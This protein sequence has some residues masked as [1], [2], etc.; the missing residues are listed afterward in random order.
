MGVQG[1]FASNFALSHASLRPAPPRRAATQG[2]GVVGPPMW[3][4]RELAQRL[5]Q[6]LGLNLFNFDVIVPLRP[7]ATQ[8]AHGSNGSL[9]QNGAQ[10]GSSAGGGG[11]AAALNGA[12]RPA[13][14]EAAGWGQGQAQQQGGPSGAP[15]Q[16]Q[17]YY[18]I[19]INYFPGYEKLPG[20]EDLMVQ[21]FRSIWPA[22]PGGG[23]Q[24]QQQQQEQQGGGAPA[25][26]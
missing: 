3:L 10:N 17:L 8:Q 2:H 9:R 20:Y 25:E 14:A 16:E 6:H 22:A 15:P 11:A 26:A 5:R 19:D 1:L 4:V 23:G 12:S 13:A 18:L 7:P 21:F 24:Q